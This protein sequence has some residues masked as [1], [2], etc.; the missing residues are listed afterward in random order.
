[1]PGGG[2]KTRDSDASL[3]TKSQDTYLKTRSQSRTLQVLLT[4][5]ESEEKKTSRRQKRRG[6]PEGER[7]QIYA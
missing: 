1:M 5:A 3:Y 4:Y 2:V 6:H 7:S